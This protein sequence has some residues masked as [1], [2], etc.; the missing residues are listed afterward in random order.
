MLQILLRDYLFLLSV[1]VSVSPYL[2]YSKIISSCIPE[3]DY[4]IIRIYECYSF[5]SNRIAKIRRVLS[6]SCSIENIRGDKFG[7][8]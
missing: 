3:W 2:Y 5:V 4:K 6:M 8:C 7:E 1:E